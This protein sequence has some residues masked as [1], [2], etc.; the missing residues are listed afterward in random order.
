MLAVLRAHRGLA[1]F[2]LDFLDT[3]YVLFAFL[4]QIV[5]IAH[6]AARRWAFD[7]ALRYG[8]LVYTLALPAVVLSAAQI[9]A[10]KPWYLWLA[11]L[12]Y[13]EWALFGYYVEYVAEIEWRSPI[14]WTVF[15]PYIG[16]YLATIMFYW[17]PLARLSEM[18]WY[19]YGA[20]F[21]VAT[22]LNLASHRRSEGARPR[23]T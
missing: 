12:L 8:P 11:G 19:V 17:W 2:N 4:F 22:A 9:A 5:L 15:I 10:G 20:L 21:L 1:M 6:F 3:L 18:L 13:A 23:L 7:F 14:R 16:L